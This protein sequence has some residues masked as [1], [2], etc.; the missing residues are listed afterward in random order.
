[1]VF[2][3]R[4]RFDFARPLIRVGS[5]S[6]P[7]ASSAMIRRSSRLPFDRTLAKD[8]V[9]VNHTFGSPAAM[10]RWPDAAAMVRAFISS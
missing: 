6:E 10:R 4:D 5:S 3:V 7:G 1:M 2:N 9:E 8:S